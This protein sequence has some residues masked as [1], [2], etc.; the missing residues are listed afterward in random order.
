M[1]VVGLLAAQTTHLQGLAY[2]G[3]YNLAFV[4]PLLITLAGV[5]NGGACAGA[6]DAEPHL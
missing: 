6:A 3:L 5:A 2:L 4:V 1:A